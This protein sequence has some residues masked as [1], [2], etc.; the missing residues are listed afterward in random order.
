[1]HSATGHVFS[2][3]ALARTMEVEAGMLLSI[4]GVL[5]PSHAATAGKKDRIE[6]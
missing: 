1:M 3:E 2:K 4:A 5:Q 6:S